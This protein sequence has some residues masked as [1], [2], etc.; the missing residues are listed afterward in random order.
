MQ[1]WKEGEFP[2]GLNSLDFKGAGHLQ[3]PFVKLSYG[4]SASED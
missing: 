2:K 1:C 4:F 3:R